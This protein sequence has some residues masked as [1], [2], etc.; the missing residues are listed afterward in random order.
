MRLKAVLP[1]LQKMLLFV[2]WVI[3]TIIYDNNE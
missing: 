3:A 2:G 1:N